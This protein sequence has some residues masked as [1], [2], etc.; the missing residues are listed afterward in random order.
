MQ[1]QRTRDTAPELALRQALHALGLRYRVDRAPIPGSP[2]RAD[3]VFT[4]QQVAVYVDG[5]FW[6]GCPEHGT[7]SKSNTAW[8]ED[9]L[10]RVRARDADTDRALTEAGWLVI[11]T[12][13]HEDPRVVAEKIQDVIR[14]R[15]A[16]G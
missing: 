15:K 1:L 14:L 11:R 12:W 7:R 13:E 5:C 4:R 8:W 16:V 2:R 9:K 6:H 10:A 3:I